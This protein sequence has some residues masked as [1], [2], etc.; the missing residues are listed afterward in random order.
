MLRFWR[1]AGVP[2]RARLVAVAAAFGAVGSLAF[3]P[4]AGAA[5]VFA[6]QQTNGTGAAP[7][8]VTVRDFNR[9]GR[10][11]LAV[12]NLFDSTVSVLLGNGDGSFQPQRWFAVGS[13]PNSVEA[14][15][16]NGDGRLDLA[17]SNGSGGNKRVGVVG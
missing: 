14:G 8:S 10:R 6:P 9:D 17:T 16:F 2:V 5:V 11:D 15:D 1:F 13:G 3:A 12:A 7:R 4:V